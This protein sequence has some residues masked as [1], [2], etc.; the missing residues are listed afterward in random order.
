MGHYN[1]NNRLEYEAK[2]NELRIELIQTENYFKEFHIS[3]LNILDIFDDDSS[4]E[5]ER[6][7]IKELN[8][9]SEITIKKWFSAQKIWDVYVTKKVS[10]NSV[11]EW[12]AMRYA[13]SMAEYLDNVRVS[14]WTE[15]SF[16]YT[17][18]SLL[19]LAE[20]ISEHQ[21]EKL[22]QIST[23]FYKFQTQLSKVY[24]LCRSISYFYW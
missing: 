7:F 19:N 5:S 6:K 14:Q 3:L 16:D 2:R 22:K 18:I 24:R 8:E 23:C 9:M 17:Y 21:N 15:Y 13:T 1:Y 10:F 11:D 20:K 4:N 12:K